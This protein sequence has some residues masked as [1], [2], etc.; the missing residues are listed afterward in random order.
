MEATTKVASGGLLAG[1]LIGLGQQVATPSMAQ[2]P[3]AL[4]DTV[5]VKLKPHLGPTARLESA[6]VGWD[7][8]SN[9]LEE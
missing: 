2:F 1:Y 8:Q 7:F 9:S 6:Q 4:C 5:P 3:L